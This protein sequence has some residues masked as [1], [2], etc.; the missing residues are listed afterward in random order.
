M[1]GIMLAIF[2]VVI[3]LVMIWEELIKVEAKL[4]I[5]AM[6]LKSEQDDEVKNE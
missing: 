4:E 2:G 6:I 1:I 3:A 5:I